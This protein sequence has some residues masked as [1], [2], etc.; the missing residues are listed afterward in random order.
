MKWEKGRW[1]AAGW[2]AGGVSWRW[3]NKRLKLRVFMPYLGFPEYVEK[4]DTVV[5]N[6][7]EGF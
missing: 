2:D 7:Y 1:G 3:R 5:N 4:C 6:A